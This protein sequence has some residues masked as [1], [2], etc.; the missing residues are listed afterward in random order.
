MFSDLED[1]VWRTPNLVMIN[2]EVSKR[3][4]VSERVPELSCTQRNKQTNNG[5]FLP[6]MH[7]WLF[8][9]AQPKIE[10]CLGVSLLPNLDMQE[11]TNTKIAKID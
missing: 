1:N 6:P 7:C 3:E 8:A 10:I 2:Y 4:A 5:F 9:I 11:A